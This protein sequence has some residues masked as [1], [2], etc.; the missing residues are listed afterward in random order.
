[1]N[2]QEFIKKNWYYLKTEIDWDWDRY[3]NWTPSVT[4]LLWLIW[5]DWF[6]YVKRHHADKLQE[7]AN[8]WTIV[9][10][11]AEHFFKKNSCMEQGRYVYFS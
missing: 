6:D 10:D 4:T 9:H 11:E 7:A 2:L 8:N 5:D 1:M 3:K